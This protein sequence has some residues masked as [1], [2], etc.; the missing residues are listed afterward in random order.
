MLPTVLFGVPGAPFAAV[1]LSLFAYLNFEMGSIDLLQDEKF[2]SSLTFGFMYGSIIVAIICL[3]MMPTV[4]SFAQ[5]PFIYYAP[6]F[7]AFIV[8]ACVQ[9][10]GGWED[11]FILFLATIMGLACK[12]YGFSRPAL[13]LGFL[14]SERIENLTIQMTSLYTIENVMS[15]PI[16]VALILFTLGVFSWGLFKK[17]Q[18]DYV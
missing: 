11:Y 13:L 9:Y 18:L 17:S 3:L 4:A 14:L 8:W 15:R 1:L 12:K 7:F 6:A 10:T 5:I 16:F 2:F